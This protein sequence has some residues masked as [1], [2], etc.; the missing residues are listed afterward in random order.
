MILLMS[1]PHHSLINDAGRIANRMRRE[2]TFTGDVKERLGSYEDLPDYPCPECYIETG[3]IV[4]LKPNGSDE[5]DRD[6]MKC[7]SCLDDY[8]LDI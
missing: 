1:P 6:L 2:G 3:N 5:Q 8:A 4:Q 7:P